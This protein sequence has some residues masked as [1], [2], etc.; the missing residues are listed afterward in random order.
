MQ[1]KTLLYFALLALMWFTALNSPALFKPDEGRYAEIPREMN[2]SGDYVT[3]RINDIK[4]FEKPPLQ[5]WGTAVFYKIFGEGDGTARLYSALTGFLCFILIFLFTNR[6]YGSEPAFIATSVLSSSLLFVGL[7]HLNILDMGLSFFLTLATLCLAILLDRYS[8]KKEY[9]IANMVF[10]IAIGLGFLSKGLIAILLPGLAATVFCVVRR[11]FSIFKRLWWVRGIL[12]F[13]AIV[14]PWVIL[15]SLRNPEFAHFFFVHEHFERFLTK[16]HGREGPIWYFI[17]V[18]ILGFFPWLFFL[19]RKRQW[20]DKTIF[21][22]IWCLSVF[23]F[24]SISSSKL[25]P[26]ILPIWPALAIL[27]GD[28]LKNLPKK[29]DIAIV[30]FSFAFLGLVLSA[31]SYFASPL[32]STKVAPEHFDSFLHYLSYAGFFLVIGAITTY[33][34]PLTRLL[35]IVVI[36]FI[37]LTSYQGIFVAYGELGPSLSSRDLAR[38]LGPQI[39]PN[40]VIYMVRY[41][42]QELP[43]YLKRFVTLVDYLGE[44]EFGIQQED[45]GRQISVE[46]FL[47]QWQRENPDAIII[48]EEVNLPLLKD[49]SYKVLYKDRRRLVLKK[50]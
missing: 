5:Y 36:S 22:V 23:G 40:T 39:T 15:C 38:Q 41:Y 27:V 20:T 10:W 7:G 26:Y 43:F 34:L 44:L 48:T 6:Y 46:E 32:V 16:V 33:F 17:P 35:K 42:E 24:F 13:L 21:L 11:D 25:T 30:I 45:R 1:K 29:W 47:K 2:A 12:I 50:Q 9:T 14:S 37:A 49:I 3:P 31:G 19:F 18:F 4:Y 8:T 28:S